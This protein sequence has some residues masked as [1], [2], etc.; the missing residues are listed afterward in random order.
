MNNWIEAAAAIQDIELAEGRAQRIAPGVEALLK[1][2]AKDP[3]RDSVELET[4]PT[5]YLLALK[6]R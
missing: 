1:A 4:D 5:S 2:A 3:L 6:P